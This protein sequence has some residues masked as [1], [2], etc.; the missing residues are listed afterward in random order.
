MTLL[1]HKITSADFASCFMSYP[2]MI[3]CLLVNQ[4]YLIYN[5]LK[6][7]DLGACCMKRRVWQPAKGIWICIHV[8]GNFY[9]GASILWQ[10]PRKI[11]KWKVESVTPCL[12]IKSKAMREIWAYEDG[13]RIR[14]S[15]LVCS[16]LDLMSLQEAIPHFLNDPNQHRGVCFMVVL[17]VPR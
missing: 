16:F 17:I 2:I 9:A 12:R 14:K 3:Y 7:E 4:A 5:P 8:L 6:R 1:S 15:V 13:T 11:V 10:S